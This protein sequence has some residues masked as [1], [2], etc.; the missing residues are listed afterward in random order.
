MIAATWKRPRAGG[1][2]S[3]SQRVIDDV[4]LY[5]LMALAA[6]EAAASQARAVALS[7]IEDLKVFLNAPTTDPEQ[8]AHFRFALTQ[9]KTFEDDPKRL[10]FP[11]PVEPPPGQPIGID[12]E[13]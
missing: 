5:Q 8:R 6:N 10:N 13:D 4:A 3:E 9:I 12:E 7:K 11:K 2:A 1:L